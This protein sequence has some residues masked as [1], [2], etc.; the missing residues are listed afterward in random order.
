MK[1]FRNQ[2]LE[3]RKNKNAVFTNQIEDPLNVVR[4]GTIYCKKHKQP[5]GYRICLI[6]RMK[7][8]NSGV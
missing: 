6:E 1:S 4:M 5:C 2:Y 3:C 7:S 8:G